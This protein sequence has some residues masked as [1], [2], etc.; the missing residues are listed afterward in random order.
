MSRLTDDI[1]RELQPKGKPRRSRGPLIG[2][3]PS[4]NGRSGG[5]IIDG[6]ITPL[7]GEPPIARGGNWWPPSG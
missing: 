4:G 3:L 7:E 2:T 6:V 1:G 5:L